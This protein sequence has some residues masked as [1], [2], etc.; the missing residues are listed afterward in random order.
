MVFYRKLSIVARVG[1]IDITF[2]S[3]TSTADTWTLRLI[4]DSFKGINELIT[5]TCPAARLAP[6]EKEA[7]ENFNCQVTSSL[8]TKRPTARKSHWENNSQSQDT[9][10]TL[11]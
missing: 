6:S 2:I 11:F 5:Y 4:A 1:R 3:S 9:V 7:E 10:L 8:V